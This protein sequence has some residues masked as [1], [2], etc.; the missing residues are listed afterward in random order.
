MHRC[1]EN[2][3]IS[4]FCPVGCQPPFDV[5]DRYSSLPSGWRLANEHDV[6]ADF[7]KVKAC[8]DS[9]GSYPI[10]RIQGGQVC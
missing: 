2:L 7:N 9:H 6:R 1:K 3:F 5:I 10:V 4:I 8:L